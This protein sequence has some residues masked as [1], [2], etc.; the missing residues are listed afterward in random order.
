MLFGSIGLLKNSL[1]HAP[2]LYF[3]IFNNKGYIYK[4]FQPLILYGL[5]LQKEGW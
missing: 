4:L 1:L 5:Y 3:I 2:T